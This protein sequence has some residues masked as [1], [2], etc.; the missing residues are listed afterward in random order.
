MK[1]LQTSRSEKSL[2]F[3][4][5]NNFLGLNVYVFSLILFLLLSISVSAATEYLATSLTGGGSGALDDISVSTLSEGDYAVVAVI[6]GTEVN[7]Y[8]YI[9]D[10]DGTDAET[11]PGIIRPDDYSTGGIWRLATINTNSL[12]MGNTKIV[13]SLSGLTAAISDATV[14]NIY[15]AKSFSTDTSIALDDNKHITFGLGV[16]I[17]NNTNSNDLF[18]ATDKEN[19]SIIGGK[20]TGNSSGSGQEAVKFVRVDNVC[21]KNG[22]YKDWIEGIH[23]YDCAEVKIINNTIYSGGRGVLIETGTD[24]LCRIE[25]NNIYDNTGYGIQYLGESDDCQIKIKNN[26]CLNN[27]RGGIGIAG[28]TYFNMEITGNHC[29]Y[30]GAYGSGGM[31][32]GINIHGVIQG[33]IA[34][35][36]CN[37]NYASGIDLEGLNSGQPENRAQFTIVSQNTCVDNG[38]RGIILANVRYCTISENMLRGNDG[39]NIGIIGSETDTVMVLNNHCYDS[40]ASASSVGNIQ[41]RYGTNILVEGNSI[42]ERDNETGTYPIWVWADASNVK[43]GSNDF[44][45]ALKTHDIVNASTTVKY[46][47]PEIWVSDEIDLSGAA[48]LEPIPIDSSIG[49]STITAAY[50]ICTEATSANP[51]V[52]IGISNGTTHTYYGT[53]TSADSASVGDK[54][55]ITLGRNGVVNSTYPTPYFYCAGGKSGAGTGKIVVK[56]RPDIVQYY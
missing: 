38:G 52:A 56:Y 40:D 32:E 41:I 50:F 29:S 3:F 35:N 8:K 42:G 43:I 46:L 24:V 19:I 16:T 28:T 5:G 14:A 31:N 55:D 21:I 25:D 6:S 30:N 39:G 2:K 10:A 17:T 47:K 45:N 36:T 15:V 27:S 13:T 53:V 34:S 20:F 37:N 22:E 23:L 54:T 48:V 1:A 26:I 9:F 7:T 33:K 18:V 12:A 11:I 44:T 4:R 51:G 49:Y